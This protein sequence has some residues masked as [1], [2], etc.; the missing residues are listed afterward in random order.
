MSDAPKY[1]AIA[2]KLRADIASGRLAVGG[3]MPTKTELAAEYDAALGTIDR[4]LADLRREGLIRSDQGAGTFILRV[5]GPVEDVPAQLA[6]L[7]ERQGETEAA[8]MDLYGKLGYEYPG[9]A[10]ARGKRKASGS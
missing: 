9:H 7:R 1:R 4:A 3:R 10:P 5:P 8:L 2:D 6:D